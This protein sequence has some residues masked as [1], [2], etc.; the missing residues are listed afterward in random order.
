MNGGTSFD[1]VVVGAGPV[2]VVLAHLL[3]LSGART[4][5]VD[6][7]RDVQRIPRA[8]ALDDDG[9][10]V[11]QALGGL[12]E[13][14][15]GLPRIER[16]RMRAASGSDLFAFDANRF[17]NGHPMLQ[18]FRQPE[19][20]DRLRAALATC[21][22][23][24]F[25]SGLTLESLMQRATTV[26]L[27]LR[28]EQGIPHVVTTGYVVGCDG[29]K[30]TVRKLVGITMV[31]S[32]YEKDWL[33]VDVLRDPTPNREVH[34]LCDPARPGVTMPAPGGGRRWEFMLGDADER[35]TIAEPDSLRRLLAPWGD[36]AAMG[37][38]RAA[39]YTFHARVADSLRRDRVFLAGDAAHLTPPFAGQ[40]LMA[41]LRDAMN[42]AWKLGL[43][44]RGDAGASLLDSYELERLP[45]AHTMVDLARLMGAVIMARDGAR[46]FLRDHVLSPASRLPFVRAHVD[47]VELKPRTTLRRGVLHRSTV[48]GVASGD[49]VPQGSVEDSGGRVHLLDDVIG[50]RFALVGI[51][52]DPNRYLRTSQRARFARLGAVVRVER[53]GRPF[54][55]EATYTD[56]DG[57]LTASL[58]DGCVLL[59]RPDRHVFAVV[60]ADELESTLDALTA[61]I[62]RASRVERP[63]FER[64]PYP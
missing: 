60:R 40:G 21:G 20:E 32:T 25:R 26:E 38:E 47:S 56:V 37:V 29:A 7:E 24:T 45:N 46:C 63:T 12:G 9:S 62:A 59:S 4:L 31:G 10:R 57:A 11:L 1:V 64:R 51:G 14:R 5:L 28:D 39:V 3:G 23:V 35:A 16:V 6:R 19:L 27:T 42:L 55:G 43:V 13:L 15:R 61:Q 34:F 48:R 44:V 41:G 52:V 49:L 17:R 2:G 22:D 36:V 53:P 58:P 54:V 30:S 18:M 8:I 33:V 50:Y